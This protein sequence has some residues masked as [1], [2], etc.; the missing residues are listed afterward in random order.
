MTHETVLVHSSNTDIPGG[1]ACTSFGGDLTH[2]LATKRVADSNQ[3]V[4]VP[5]IFG[6]FAYQCYISSISSFTTTFKAFFIEDYM[7]LKR[8]KLGI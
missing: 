3:I 8:L 5:H 1:C 6:F 7:K 4:D 2:S